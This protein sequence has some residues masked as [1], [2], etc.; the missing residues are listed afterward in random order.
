MKQL[1]R[2]VLQVGKNAIALLT[3]QVWVRML[4][5]ML[6]AL[7]ARFE[8]ADGL[9][10]YVLVQTFVGITGAVADLGLNTFLTREAARSAG[11][12]DQRELL[13]N[14]LLLKITLALI[15]YVVLVVITLFDPFPKATGG[16]LLLGGLSLL[17]N[18]AMNTIAAFINARQRMEI[19]SGLNAIVRLLTM[20]GALPA[21]AWGYGVPGVLI[22]TVGA[23]LLGLL[24]HAAVL[25]R[26]QMLPS[27]R[28]R[29]ATWKACLT[30]AYPFALTTIIASVYT[31]LDL[32]LISIWHG[33]VAVGWYSAAYKIWE[34]VSLIPNS[35]MNALFPVMSRLWSS[36]EGRHRLRALFNTGGWAMLSGGLLLAFGGTWAGSL[37][38]SIIYGDGARYAP[39][40]MV[41]RIL[42]WAIPAMFLYLLSGYTLYAAR[43]Q[44]QVA[45][46]MWLVGVLNVTLNLIVIPRWSYLGAAGVTL[47][48][49]WLLGGILLA[50]ARHALVFVETGRYAS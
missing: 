47:F 28:V 21:L 40:V 37:F 50:R 19:T 15:G 25:R 49:E 7:I 9:G 30:E 32:V 16:L 27:Y 36:Q 39:A 48:T 44:R 43:K 38:I 8:G 45:Q 11:L 31:R 13:S 35:L 42:V 3:A 10:R 24:F 18:A 2:A 17:P 14:V 29:L 26:W 34:V 5:L 33:D 1:G 12:E 23:S 6:V 20:V 41:F 46:V 22:F 4:S